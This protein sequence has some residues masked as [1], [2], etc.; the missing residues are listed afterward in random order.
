M[1]AYQ[2]FKDVKGVTC[3]NVEEGLIKMANTEAYI[4]DVY[5]EVYN[6]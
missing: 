4:H 5:E 1:R 6:V 2:T 3:K